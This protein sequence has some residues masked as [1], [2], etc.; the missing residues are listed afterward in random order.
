MIKAAVLALLHMAMLV[1]L[2]ACD[3]E[4]LKRASPAEEIA[5]QWGENFQVVIA[6]GVAE[7]KSMGS[8]SV[9]LYQGNPAGGRR[10][11]FIA[12]L[13]FARDGFLK[14][15]EFAD[16]DNDQIEDLVVVFESA[17][18]GDYLSAHAW[19]L[20]DEKLSAIAV[21]EGLAFDADVSAELRLQIDSLNAL[22]PPTDNNKP[23]F[24]R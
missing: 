17:G 10:D 7:P 22:Q 23:V 1:M 24:E 8:Y 11:F 2:M 13:I 16:I 4:V 9:R 6:E 18:T 14:Q 21:V 3:S 15:A 20:V 12:G 19:R 5:L